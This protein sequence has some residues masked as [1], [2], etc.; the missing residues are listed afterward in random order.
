MLKTLIAAREWQNRKYLISPAIDFLFAGGLAL[1]IMPMLFVMFPI[2]GEQ[3]V[4]NKT[5]FHVS[6]AFATLAYLVNHPHFMASY[7]IMYAGF[8][9]KLSYHKQHPSVYWRYMVAGVIVPVLLVA[10]FIYAFIVQ[11]K[12]VFAFGI[13]ILFFTVGWHYVKQAFG[14]FIMLSALKNIYYGKNIRRLLLINCWLVWMLSWLGSNIWVQGYDKTI[15]NFWGVT[16]SPLGI[17]LPE[18]VMTLLHYSVIVYGIAVAAALLIHAVRTRKRPS[19]TGL[20]GYSTMYSLLLL[21]YYHPLWI[22]MTPF[23]HSAQ[24]LL[25]VV[26]YKRGEAH[27]LTQEQHVSQKEASNHIKRFVLI[28]FFLGLLLFTGIPKTLEWLTEDAE[29][30]QGLFLPFLY[31]FTLFINVHHYF[32]DNVIWRKENTQVKQYLTA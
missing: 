4:D 5:I 26:A 11:D 7:Q 13:Q 16:Y 28:A 32:I 23:L 18:Y 6:I 20:A 21:S 2:S 24:Y 25:F 9:H 14:I 17:G 22:Y 29:Q 27:V 15:N 19:M 30:T 10:Y 31:A 12:A 8:K 3:R 1:I